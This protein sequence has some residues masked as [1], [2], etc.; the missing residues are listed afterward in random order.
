MR[1]AMTAALMA[2]AM[3]CGAGDR[4][5]Q[6]PT[7]AAAARTLVVRDTVVQSSFEASGLAMPVERA[8]LSTKLMGSVTRVLVRE[9]DRVAR[10]ALLAEVDARDVEAKR[11]QVAASIRAAEA[12]H[13]DA[14]TQAARFRALYADSAATR[15]QLD[16]VETGLAR[17]EAGLNAARA[18][19]AEVEAVG[20]YAE[21]RA[22]FPGLVTRRHVDP[23]A[24]VAPGVPVVEVQQDDRLRL[25]VTAPP[26]AARGLRRGQVLE[27]IIEGRPAHATI[28]GVFPAGAGAVYTIN[29][30]VANPAGEFPAGGAATLRVP[31]GE[32]R[33]ILLPAAALH[34]EGD[35]T[36]VR[37]QTPAGAE[38]RFVK[39]AGQDA[40][41]GASPAL[42]EVLSGLV[43]G[44]VI[45]LGDD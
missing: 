24:F 6:A 11:V 39:V 31:Q 22:P 7:Q 38:L 45:L 44:D 36:G 5:A 14:L 20:D 35:L 43:P 13:E 3:A 40:D 18:A 23:G 17:A 16:Q 4:P 10:G 15:Y 8:V 12:V 34:R 2:G 32:R 27:A 1:V 26:S 25:G 41:G 37:I 33:T 42:V 9:G 28:E 30:V 21:I 19:G 29:A